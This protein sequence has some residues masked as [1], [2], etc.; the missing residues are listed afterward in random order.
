[1]KCSKCGK[2]LKSKGKDYVLAGKVLMATGTYQKVQCLKCG[3]I[4]KS[5]L[6]KKFE[7]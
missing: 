1:M 7:E 3:R 4:Q 5:E 2:D 6:I